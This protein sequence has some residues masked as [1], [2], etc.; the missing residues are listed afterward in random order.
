MV[1]NESDTENFSFVSQ[2]IENANV[3]FTACLVIVGYLALGFLSYRHGYFSEFWGHPIFSD[4]TM[5][6]AAIT[7]RT[8]FHRRSPISRHR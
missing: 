6:I 2:S 5:K 8:R 4:L 7:P 3:N 1:L